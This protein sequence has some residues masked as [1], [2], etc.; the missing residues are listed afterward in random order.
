MEINSTNAYMIG[1]ALRSQFDDNNELQSLFSSQKSKKRDCYI[2]SPSFANFGS[3]EV[4][5]SPKMPSSLFDVLNFEYDYTRE[6][7]DEVAV[8]GFI[9]SKDQIPQVEQSRCSEIKANNNEVVINSGKY[10]KFQDGEGNTHAMSCAYGHLGQLNSNTCRGLIDDASY[11]RG[12]FWNTLAQ[13]ATYISMHYPEDTQKQIL[14]ESGISE[15]FFS[16]QIDARKSEY[17]YSNGNCGVAISKQRYDGDYN[18]FMSGDSIL[19]DFKVGSVFK[20]SGKEYT[21]GAYKKLDI[22]YG[23]DIYTMEYPP[24]SEHERKW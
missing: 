22:P 6:S 8:G 10:Y 3:Y 14:N 7:E 13:D 1:L 2:P 12:E 17:Y 9:F 16:V 24:A 5:D 21:L 20:I 11:E 19:N 15:G 4:S 18:C 23:A